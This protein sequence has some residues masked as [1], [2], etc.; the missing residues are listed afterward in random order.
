MLRYIFKRLLMMIPVMLGVVLVIFVMLS[1][2]PGDPAVQ[3]LG[4]DATPEQLEEL[5]DDLGL[6][7][8]FLVRY[9]KYVWNLLHGDLGTSY[10]TKQ[11]VAKEIFERFPTTLLFTTLACIVGAIVGILFGI[12]SAVKQYTWFDNVSRVI[13]L[14]GISVPSFWLGLMFIIWFSVGLGWFPSSGFYGPKYWV[15]PSLT[16]GLVQASNVMRQ[17]RSAMLDVVRQDYIRTARAKGQSEMKVIFSH[18]L[19][20]ALIPIVTVLGMQFG[21]GMGGSIISEQV[22]AIPG[23]GMLM[24]NAIG[25]LNYPV[26]QGGVLVIA[27]SFSIVNLL[28][29]ILYAFI[30]PRIKSLYSGKKRVRKTKNEFVREPGKESAANG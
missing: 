7:D 24:T 22:F 9:V 26:V 19:P 15:L 27:L 1:L 16:V 12:V 11:P 2:S 4:P 5:R 20:N 29:D 14:I 18:E 28:I 3:M 13:A 10:T 6:N 8:P 17:T 23:I 21:R 25:N 30:D